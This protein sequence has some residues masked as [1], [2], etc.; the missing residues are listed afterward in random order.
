MA[1]AMGAIFVDV[2]TLPDGAAGFVQ[3]LFLGAIYAYVLFQGP[4]LL[5]LSPPPSLEI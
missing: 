2:K 5:L 4:L 3:V 1:S